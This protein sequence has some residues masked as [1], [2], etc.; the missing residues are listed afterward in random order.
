[1]LPHMATN[2]A[3]D[4]P[5]IHSAVFATWG[6]LA[7]RAPD[8]GGRFLAR[9]LGGA[10]H[11]RST[12]VSSLDLLTVGTRGRDADHDLLAQ[13]LTSNVTRIVRPSVSEVTLVALK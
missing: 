1:M 3:W 13:T 10:C 12:R 7:D 8:A 9:L 4:L 5:H 6:S 2:I 11:R